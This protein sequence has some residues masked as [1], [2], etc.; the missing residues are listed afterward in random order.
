MPSGSP[1]K[2]GDN[3]AVNRTSAHLG[4]PRFGAFQKYALASTASLAVLPLS[5][6]LVGAG[7][8]ILNLAAVVSALHIHLGLPLP[9]VSLPSSSSAAQPAEQKRVLVYGGSSSCGGL[10]VRYLLTA[11]IDVVTTSSPQNKEFVTSLGKDL[12]GSSLQIIDHKASKEEIIEALR[13]NG[14]Y[15]AVFDSIG[16]APVTD[17]VSTYLDSVGGGSYNALIPHMGEKPVPESV[18]RKFAAYSW[19]FDEEKW[20]D[21]RDWFY[22]EYMPKGLDS[23]AIVPTR[24]HEIKG[25]LGKVQ[26]ALDLMMK[27]GVSGRKLVMDPWA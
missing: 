19:A 10:A 11:G 5:V 9:P 21:V 25:G 20:K 14:P 8:S 15:D 12:P 22:G 27:G 24:V 23:G 16:L 7:A 3:V 1:F 6:D 13:K 18:E 2:V 26:E 4:D 17:I